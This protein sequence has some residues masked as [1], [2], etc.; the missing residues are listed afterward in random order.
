MTRCFAPL[1]FHNMKTSIRIPLIAS[2]VA[3]VVVGTVA[4]AQPPP[5]NPSD[6]GA[7]AG[8]VPSPGRPG[9]GYPLPLGRIV[10]PSPDAPPP[11]RTP[12]RGYRTSRDAGDSN[13]AS[14]QRVLKRR[15]YYSGP[16]DGEA[17]GGTG[18]AIRG[19]RSENGLGSSTRIDGP[20][21]S[22]LGL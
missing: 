6:S 20:L 15:G 7:G 21:L 11:S 12:H 9:S 18:R 1:C 3:A 13:V 4:L 2:L 14:V 22:A 19:F 8:P 10:L 5:R 16:V 17:G